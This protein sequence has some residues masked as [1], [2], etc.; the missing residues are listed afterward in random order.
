MRGCCNAWRGCRSYACAARISAGG[1]CAG[2]SSPG[3][4]GVVLVWGGGGGGLR[5]QGWRARAYRRR[6]SEATPR[7]RRSG[8]GLGVSSDF[9]F[10]ESLRSCPLTTNSSPKVAGKSSTMASQESKALTLTVLGSGTY[11][12]VSISQGSSWGQ[13]ACSQSLRQETRAL[14][15]RAC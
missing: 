7:R 10:P 6:A 13:A 15:G 9:Q 12:I 1:C 8:P 3:R 11:H 14:F 2:L 4:Y 5:P